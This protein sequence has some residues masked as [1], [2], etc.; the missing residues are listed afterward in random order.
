[1]RGPKPE[2]SSRIPGFGRSSS[3]KLAPTPIRQHSSRFA[4]SSDEEDVRP[5]FRSRFVDSDSDDDGDN[6]PPPRSSGFGAGTMRVNTPVRGI[7]KHEGVE[8]GDSSDL[9]DSDDDKK[10]PRLPFS[11]GFKLS[12]NRQ[13]GSAAAGSAQGM[14]LASGSL[15]RSGSGRE[16]MGSPP[17]T[18]MITAGNSAR[19]N[20]TRRGSFMGVLRRKKPDPS[21]KVRKLDAESAARRDTPLERSKSDLAA[22]KRQESYSSATGASPLT[23]KL[24]KK[25]PAWPLVG[26]SSEK[27]L[28]GEDGRPF[29]ADASDGVVGGE[30]NGV[31]NGD[32]ARPDLGARRFT[33]TGLGDVDL[34][35]VAKGRKKKKFGALRRMFRLDD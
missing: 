15:R 17:T 27:I 25:S 2:K 24:Q 30:A 16:T 6:V 5:A 21:S 14:T 1:M 20:H 4:D 28:G 9:P 34:N 32:T 7:P 29:S 12:K 8:N 22:V 19:P 33:A 3:T 11:P 31:T 18:T 26:D 10:S 13:N 23:P 35:G